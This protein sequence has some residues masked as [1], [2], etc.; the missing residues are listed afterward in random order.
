MRIFASLL[1]SIFFCSQGL[2]SSPA[3]QDECVRFETLPSLIEKI[4]KASP[5]KTKLT[6]EIV[7][8]AHK[9]FVDI[10]DPNRIYFL[11]KEITPFLDVSKKESFLQ[12]CLSGSFLSYRNLVE[13]FQSAIK[14]SKNIRK[15]EGF[16]SIESLRNDSPQNEN[17]LE[18]KIFSFFVLKQGGSN[19]L[20][21][22]QEKEQIWIDPS[23]ECIAQAILKSILLSL[24]AHS[25]VLEKRDARV[26][27]EKL[28]KEAFGTGLVC[29]A[30]DGV[31][32]LA[33][34]QQGSPAEKLAVFQRGD[35]ILCLDGVL[36]SSMSLNEIEE[37]LREGNY[38][39]VLVQYCRDGII[40]EESVP[41]RLF[42][43][44][45]DRVH[46][47]MYK[48]ILVLTI[49]SFYTGEHFRISTSDD[50]T[51][52]I[53]E[54]APF[55]G[56]VLDVRSNGG[57]YLAEAVRTCGLFLKTGV[58]MTALYANGEKIV[59]RDTDP[60]IL[61]DGPM[62]VLVSEW[63]ASA[64]EILTK[65][66]QDY[67][68]ALV[69]GSQRTY[70]KGSI[71]LQTITNTKETENLPLRY[72][73]GKFYSVSGFS[74]DGKGVKADIFIPGFQKRKEHPSL[75]GA[76]PKS[77]P[78]HFI[79]RLEDI[80]KSDRIV[81]QKQYLPYISKRKI[82]YREHIPWLKKMSEERTRKA[83]PK[84]LLHQSEFS[85]QVSR[86][87]VQEA[88]NILEDLLLIERN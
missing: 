58:V 67:G 64:A 14:R 85:E 35:H 30:S 25:D 51:K 5:G 34:I 1:L 21:E 45:D 27:R 65:T 28:M 70:G 42:A 78:P 54:S 38:G 83:F 40:L 44:G 57:G 86:F 76:L 6:G 72:T 53:K 32:T 10:L 55:S 16:Y 20:T 9:R 47:E 18:Q 49:P 15:E 4:V 33:S 46:G 36:C 84:L 29:E 48:D 61:F 81:Y 62:V 41:K 71:Q 26:L 37:K 8:S 13:V 68:N 7:L 52:I 19:A 17:E 63:T 77:I 43:I 31:I 73:V 79:D 69:V 80:R 39:S 11:E 59:Y 88:E 12:E 2:I 3:I 75:G 22:V 24:D 87:Q 23:E 60:T 50:I 74:P 66:L 56:L 82:I